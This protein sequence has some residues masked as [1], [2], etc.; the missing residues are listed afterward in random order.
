[1]VVR[2]KDYARVIAFYRDV[3][4]CSVEREVSE[5]GITQ[6]RAGTALI[7]VVDATGVLGAR[8]GG[9]PDHTVPNMD[10]FCVQVLPWDADAIL[11]H[12]KSH[13]VT[14]GPPESRYG[15]LGYGPSIYAQDPEGNTVELKGPPTDGSGDAR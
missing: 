14:A 9:V 3:L 7:D 13:G 4:G 2:A 15:A 1:M 12:L 8:G 10:H 5:M 6:L 11:Q